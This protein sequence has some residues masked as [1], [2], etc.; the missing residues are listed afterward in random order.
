MQDFKFEG[1]VEEYTW[2]TFLADSFVCNLDCNPNNWGL[3]RDEN[4]LYVS[5]PFFDFGS[6]R[7][8]RFLMQVQPFQEAIIIRAFLGIVYTCYAHIFLYWAFQNL[9]GCLALLPTHCYYNDG[10]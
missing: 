5:A 10:L 9:G 2:D 3:F 4:G 7:M 6:S 1:S 8:Q